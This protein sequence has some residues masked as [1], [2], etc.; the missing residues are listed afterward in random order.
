MERRVG[1]KSVKIDDLGSSNE[2]ESV[3]KATEGKRIFLFYFALF[4]IQHE[5]SAIYG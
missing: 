2:L 3:K 5:F 1:G 4:G